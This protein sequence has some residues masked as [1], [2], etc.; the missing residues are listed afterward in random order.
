MRRITSRLA[1]TS[2]ELGDRSQGFSSGSIGPH[3]QAIDFNPSVFCLGGYGLYY[4]TLHK[5]YARFRIR[6]REGKG[7]FDKL[8]GAEERRL[9]RDGD[10]LRIATC[11][12]AAVE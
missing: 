11:P 3:T 7:Q 8:G 5:Y 4:G 2:R 1:L 9:G 6:N 12:I 10:W